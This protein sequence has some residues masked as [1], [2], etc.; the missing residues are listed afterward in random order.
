VTA[1][2]VLKDSLFKKFA[3]HRRRARLCYLQENVLDVLLAGRHPQEECPSH[4][5]LI[6]QGGRVFLCLRV[7]N[8]AQ[9]VQTLLQYL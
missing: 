6:A 7:Q 9:S 4:P 2:G 8:A 1:R 3:R 5:F